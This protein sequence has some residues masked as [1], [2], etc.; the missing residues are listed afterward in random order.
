MTRPAPW[1]RYIAVPLSPRPDRRAQCPWRALLAVSPCR[2]GV[3]DRGLSPKATAAGEGV[4]RP[5]QPWGDPCTSRICRQG[6]ITPRSG[7]GDPSNCSQATAGW[8]TPRPGRGSNTILRPRCCRHPGSRAPAA[9]APC[10]R[11]AHSRPAAARQPQ[12]ASA[13]LSR[14]GR[15]TGPGPRVPPHRAPGLR[16]RSSASAPRPRWRTSASGAGR[17]PPR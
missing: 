16:G 7:G 8:I 12:A 11:R 4:R 14:S 5:P 17:P 3:P 13:G 6:W 2:S 9:S 10:R 15:P 1:P